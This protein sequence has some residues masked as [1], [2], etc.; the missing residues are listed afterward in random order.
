MSMLKPLPIS[1]QHFE[2][3]REKGAV[4]VDKTPLIYNLATHGKAYFLSR[5]R[6]FGKSLLISTFD[7]L[8]SGKKN[9]F[10]GLWMDQSDWDW[11]SHPVKNGQ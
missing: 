5:P 3:L 11:K 10:E 6:R 9:L 7:A 2:E 1:I 4:Y 8:F